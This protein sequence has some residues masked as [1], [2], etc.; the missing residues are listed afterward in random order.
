VKLVSVAV[1]SRIE[2]DLL[3]Y[4]ILLDEVIDGFNRSQRMFFTFV[5]SGARP[6]RS[7]TWKGS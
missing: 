2:S 1:R 6:E 5:A 3:M 4:L 7:E